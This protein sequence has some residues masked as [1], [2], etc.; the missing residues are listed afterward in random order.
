MTIPCLCGKPYETRLMQRFHACQNCD[1]IWDLTP[2]PM[3]TTRTPADRVAQVSL[4][5]A[6][7]R[8]P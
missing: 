6:E 8:T 4:S 2:P 7:M 1:H 3:T 5:I